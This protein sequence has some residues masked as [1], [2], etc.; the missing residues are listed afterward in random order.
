MNIGFII[1][2]DLNTKTGGYIYDQKLVQY[3][4]EQ[5]ENVRIISLSERN[6]SQAIVEN[7]TADLWR[8]ISESNIDI[9]VQDELTHPS[10]FALNSKIKRKL[11]IPIISIVHVL[12]KNLRD[13]ARN[14][15]WRTAVEKRYLRSV[16]GFV[17]ISNVTRMDVQK[18]TGESKP[19]VT[20][21]PAGD[22]FN[23][24]TTHTHI[25]KRSLENGSLKIL[26]LGNVTRN[27]RLHTLIDGLA[28]I[29][30]HYDKLT[31]V[32][33]LK[34]EPEYAVEIERDI[35]QRGLEGKIHLVGLVHGQAAIKG[36]LMENHIMAVPSSMEG[37]AIAY[38][39]AMGFGLPVIAT[40]NGASGE[41]IED[42]VNGFLVEP[43]DSDILK[44]IIGMLN[45]DRN[46]L[47]TMSLAAKKAFEKHP[48]WND[49]CQSIFTFLKGF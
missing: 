24:S 6:Y 29:P 35:A 4:R 7:Y 38:V 14:D 28:Q 37:M 34:V 33:S 11:K 18:F 23:H 8:E 48:T 15:R 10:L 36:Y 47:M 3:L 49:T 46:K 32:G 12:S 45:E 20:A 30:E 26:F 2:G 41:L 27:K 22:R 5:G 16:D 40:K 25:R 9:L 13:S 44:Q 19:F 39:E 42:T 1:Y 43:G 31:V 17:F 21:Y